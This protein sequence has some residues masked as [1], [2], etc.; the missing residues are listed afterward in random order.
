[1]ATKKMNCGGSAKAKR[2]EEGGVTEGPN[3]NIGDDVRARAMA[4]MAARDSGVSS[5]PVPKAAPKKEAKLAMPDYSNED[6]DRMDAEATAAENKRESQALYNKKPV[7]TV[8]KADPA[9]VAK[10]Y[11]DAAELKKAQ[12]DEAKKP[13]PRSVVFKKAGGSVSSKPK[14]AGRLATRGYGIAKGGKK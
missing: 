12:M 10:A 13:L 1:M 2:Y 3:K 4:A 6:L 5:T 9:K 11:R 14:V 7:D 8:S